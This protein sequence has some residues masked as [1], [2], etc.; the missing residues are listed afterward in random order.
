M[1][2]ELGDIEMGTFVDYVEDGNSSLGSNNNYSQS[3]I[4]H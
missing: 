1:I 2:D 3:F 4:I